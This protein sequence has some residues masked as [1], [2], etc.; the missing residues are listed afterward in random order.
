MRMKISSDC[1][2]Y[3][4]L[5]LRNLNIRNV[6]I[7]RRSMARI[8]FDIERKYEYALSNKGAVFHDKSGRE[9]FRAGNIRLE[10]RY[11]EMD[12]RVRKNMVQLCASELAISGIGPISKEYA[13]KLLSRCCNS[14]LSK[15]MVKKK[16]PAEVEKP[17]L[18]MFMSN[19]NCSIFVRYIAKRRQCPL[20]RYYKQFRYIF[21]AIFPKHVINTIES[22]APT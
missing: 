18:S 10:F 1:R 20:Y 6:I 14:P 5:S 4:E 11:Y 22:T 17:G 12:R 13:I 15:L 21:S 3:G 2:Y 16:P 7:S 19:L 9:I 8:Y